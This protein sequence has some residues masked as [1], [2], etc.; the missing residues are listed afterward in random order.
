MQQFVGSWS[1]TRLIVPTVLKEETNSC[2]GPPMGARVTLQ[3]FGTEPD[4]F[5]EAVS[6]DP[7]QVRRLAAHRSG[8]DL[9]NVGSPFFESLFALCEELMPLVDRSHTGNRP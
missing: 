6:R 9:R 3:S 7:S 2:V 5:N 1:V 4:G 8:Q